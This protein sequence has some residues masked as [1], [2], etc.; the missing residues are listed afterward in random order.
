MCRSTCA[1]LVSSVYGLSLTEMPVPI[2]TMVPSPNVI[3]RRRLGLASRAVDPMMADDEDLEFHIFGT[4]L[5]V[6]ALI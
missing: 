3:L 1:K 5:E 6:D 2:I 4:R